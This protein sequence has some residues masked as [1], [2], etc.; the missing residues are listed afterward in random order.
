MVITQ[1]TNK[2]DWRILEF[3]MPISEARKVGDEFLITGIAI[4]ETTTRNGIKY[5][6]DELE[7]AAQSFRGKPILLDHENKVQNIVGRTTENVNFNV[8]K[9][10]I[11]F[12]A[13]IVD[14][15]IREKINQGLITDVSIGASVK[16]LTEEEDGSRKAVGLEG[17]EIS[18]VAVP[19]DP[20][21][22]IAQAMED[23]F[24]IRESMLNKLKGGIKEMAEEEEQKQEEK[25]EDEAPE[26]E[27]KEEPVVEPAEEKVHNTNVNVDMSAVTE[28][29]KA[30]KDEIA[31]LK[32]VKE[33]DAEEPEAPTEPVED[34]T[35]GEVAA[36]EPEAE[37][38][39]TTESLVLEQAETG[40]GFAIWRDYSKESEDTK[41]KRLIR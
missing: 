31:D 34:E 8:E 38:E 25:T 13:R 14:E 33:E 10:G 39:E 7:N 3:I 2:K 28:A 36:E 41:L 23:S 1:K 11:Q 26:E 6:V 22:N 18:L 21:A 19:G 35:K 17:M 24:M 9:K 37:A 16:D 15:D 4:N 29:I 20:N 5:T 32:K 30:L 27:A 40:K 12:E